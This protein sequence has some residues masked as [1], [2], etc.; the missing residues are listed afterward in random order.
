MP[1]NL[2]VHPAY[3]KAITLDDQ[4]VYCVLNQQTGA[5][6]TIIQLV[7]Q[8]DDWYMYQLQNTHD[9]ET[10][11]WTVMSD[12]TKSQ[13]I[14]MTSEQICHY[15]AKPEYANPKGAWQV[16]RNGQYGFGKFTHFTSAMTEYAIL[17]FAEDALR[18][19]IRLHKLE[20]DAPSV[21]VKPTL[22]KEPE[23][24]Y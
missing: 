14:S 10:L 16:M 15:L 3:G 24:A 17:V 1:D 13:L 2:Y 6:Q 5:V 4:G 21:D 11:Y 8:H 9:E 19:V 7:Y 20:E 22:A 12:T 18:G 23:L